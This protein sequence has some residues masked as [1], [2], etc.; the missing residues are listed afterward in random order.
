M[1]YDYHEGE[2]IDNSII[3][4]VVGKYIISITNASVSD[5]FSVIMAVQENC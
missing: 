2:I 5:V 3:M 4:P 1:V